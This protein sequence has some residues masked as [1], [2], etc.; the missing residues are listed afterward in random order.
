[1]QAQGAT[2][3]SLM[4]IEA[5]RILAMLLIV[6]HH[7][8]FHGGVLQTSLFSTNY[9]LGW[10]INAFCY[11]GVDCYVL[12]SGYFLVK[13]P[14]FKIK[15]A[16]KLWIQIFFYSVAIF[17]LF[18]SLNI[19]PFVWNELLK[20]SFP[21]LRKAYWF[22]TAYMWLYFLST[23]LNKFITKLSKRDY[24]KL[25]ALLLLVF[26]ILPLLGADPLHVN[27]G[28]NLMWFIVLYF[29]GGYIRLFDDFNEKKKC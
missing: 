8:L 11:V 22:V 18:S 12:I 29:I 23:Y 16:F 7:Y 3:R 4:G 15:K 5:L 26:S 20:A 17:L 27:K 21:V 9:L 28:Y 6:G 2:K 10:F 24:Q 13:S 14:G 1:M 19:I 25:I